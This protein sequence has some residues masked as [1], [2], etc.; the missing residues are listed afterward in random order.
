[1]RKQLDSDLI[2]INV[3]NLHQFS[4]WQKIHQATKRI[5]PQTKILN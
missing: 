2:A 1:M 3:K 5:L 4:T